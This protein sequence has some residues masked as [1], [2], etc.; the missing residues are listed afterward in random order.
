MGAPQLGLAELSRLGRA[1][2]L[3]FLEL[4]TVAGSTDLPGLFARG[5]PHD[6]RLPVRV[7]AS[8]L[9]LLDC[10]ESQIENFLRY[11]AVADQFGA[12][13]VRVFGG[14]EIDRMVT[15]GDLARVGAVL[16]GC[17]TE[18]KRR[19]L[20]GEILL[21]THFAFSSARV[22]RRLN[23]WLDE[24]VSILWDSHHTW[25]RCGEAPAEAWSLIGPWVRHVHYKDSRM[26][27]GGKGDG[28]YVPPGQ[29]EF[30][31]REL[32]ELLRAENFEEGLSL[33]WEKLW[34]PEL[35]DLSEVLP[36]FMK[37]AGGEAR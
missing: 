12:P 34:H 32:M 6:D 31:S 26:E 9:R 10:D 7:V 3:D 30:P 18:M 19:G 28:R 14:G 36:H 29:G 25:R 15:E 17:R 8:D 21:E 4:R 20:R 5:I 33:E 2:S 37:I 23:E 16:A 1:F 22:C 24:P 35:P 27:P 11:A 13:Y